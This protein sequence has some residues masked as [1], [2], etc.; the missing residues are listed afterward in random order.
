MASRIFNIRDFG[1]RGGGADDTQAIQQALF[2]LLQGGGGV[3][4]IPTG[5]YKLTRPLVATML[6]VSIVIRGEGQGLSILEADHAGDLLQFGFEQK[7]ARQPYGLEMAGVGL[8]CI[9]RCGTALVVDYGNPSVTN[10]HFQPSTTLR[11]VVVASGPSGSWANGIKISDAWNVTMDNVYV[12]GDSAGG[13]W[14]RMSGNGIELARMCVNS[15]FSNVRCNF[16]ATGFKYDAGDGPNTEGLFFTNCSM[17]AV[18]RGV[19]LRGNPNAKAAR[20]STLTWC[21]GL[22]EAR[23]GGVR[24]GSAAFHLQHVWTAL[25]SGCQMITETITENV[26]NTYALCVQDCSGVVVVGCDLNAWIYGVLTTGHC[27][28]ISVNGNTYT[29]VAT[30]VV[31]NA[32][33]EG[34]RS[35]GAVLFNNPPREVDVPG[36]NQMGF[37]EARALSA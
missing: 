17:V 32:G 24:N 13:I 22:I 34:S 15:H 29:N 27:R 33:T 23:V 6:Q 20:V 26:E 30:Q 14:D 11:D 10:D 19:W 9:G 8:R 25:I 28:A 5:R 18:K 3:L 1:A 37:V 4:F 21:G 36:V 16:W 12:S 2:E 31:F 7:G 35:Y